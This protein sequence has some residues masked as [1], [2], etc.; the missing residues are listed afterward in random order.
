MHLSSGEKLKC[1]FRD[2]SFNLV[3]NVYYCYV[4]SLD[5]Y[6]NNMTID[7]FT[8]V[9]D[10]MIIPLELASLYIHRIS[11]GKCSDSRVIKEHIERWES[12]TD[13]V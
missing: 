10:W 6:L 9:W 5:N 12:N 4:T 13:I 8:G 1:Q 7:G 3:G 2:G 11:T